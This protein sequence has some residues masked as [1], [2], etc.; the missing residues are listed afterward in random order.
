MLITFLFLITI[1]ILIK[2]NL[3]TSILLSMFFTVK[4]NIEFNETNKFIAFILFLGSSIWLIIS[5]QFISIWLAMECQ[6]FSLV[7]LMFLK[8]K[9][10]IENIESIIKYFI[11]SAFGGL[12]FLV[13]IFNLLNTLGYSNLNNNIQI[14]S[15]IIFI[16]ISTPLL[17]KLGIAPLHYW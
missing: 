14:S 17:L 6:S 10:T 11:I 1:S 2:I 8:N 7:L 13:G 15:N 5:K 9:L 3:K 4:K 12:I 16:L